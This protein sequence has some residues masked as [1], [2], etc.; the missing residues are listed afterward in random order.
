M[1]CPFPVQGADF[2]QWCSEQSLAV[3]GQICIWEQEDEVIP[4]ICYSPPNHAEP[5]A[6][7]QQG[8]N[9]PQPQPEGRM[10]QGRMQHERQPQKEAQLRAELVPILEQA[11]AAGVAATAVALAP[12]LEAA[13]PKP[14][15]A[16][17]VPA[18]ASRLSSA[19]QEGSSACASGANSQPQPAQPAQLAAA[20]P[21]PAQ[22]VES[23]IQRRRSVLHGITLIASE[24]VVPVPARPPKPEVGS[25]CPMCNGPA[26]QISQ[27][28]WCHRTP[29]ANQY[30]CNPCN[31]HLYEQH[32]WLTSG[33]QQPQPSAQRRKRS[34][35]AA[36]SAQPQPR[37]SVQQPQ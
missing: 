14:A 23:G 11:A 27:W 20:A 22:E 26:Q 33:M 17:A 29:F 21:G 2:E 12:P 36:A 35:Q 1:S 18:P 13:A 10:Q 37:D 15:P 5:H 3:G 30:I 16:A 25:L 24:Q 34:W 7:D 19:G 32:Q 28:R 4:M 8:A 31:M 6:A 9:R